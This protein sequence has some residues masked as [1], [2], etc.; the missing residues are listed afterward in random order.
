MKLK[1][2]TAVHRELWGVQDRSKRKDRK[3]GKDSAKK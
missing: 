2:D 3:K 1:R